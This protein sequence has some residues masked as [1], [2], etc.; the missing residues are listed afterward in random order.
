MLQTH[1]VLERGNEGMR[2]GVAGLGPVRGIVVGDKGVSAEVKVSA[3]VAGLADH[4]KSHDQRRQITRLSHD[5]LT[6]GRTKER[7]GS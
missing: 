3:A 6:S 4:L 7:Q 1:S 5:L 2:N